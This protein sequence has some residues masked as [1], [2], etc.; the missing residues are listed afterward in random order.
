M[1]ER[2]LAEN[3]MKTLGSSLVNIDDVTLGGGNIADRYLK[4]L[5]KAGHNI[6]EYNNCFE[7]IHHYV[8]CAGYENG[9][10]VYVLSDYRL[11]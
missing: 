8:V 11:S 7:A 5:T 9:K 4:M 2:E 1:E 10:L 3:I 6:M